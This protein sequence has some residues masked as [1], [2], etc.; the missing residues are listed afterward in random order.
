[1]TY[2]T[3][4]AYY[5]TSS[6]YEASSTYEPSSSYYEDSSSYEPS[7]TY[8]QDSSVYAPSSTYASEAPSDS[9]LPSSGGGCPAVWTSVAK[10]L[11]SLFI[12]A[13]GCNDDARAAI[14]AVFHDCFP[15]GGCDGSLMLEEELSRQQNT[16]LAATVR[17]L[18][19]IADQYNVG[20]GDMIAFAGC[21][22]PIC[23]HCTY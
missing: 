15:Q 3:T 10:E 4:T 2:T 18:K 22:C 21:K 5:E 8:Y 14:R 6:A 20:H 13:G 9:S 1:V 7:S 11:S 12:S 19:S 17:K 23:F 16:P